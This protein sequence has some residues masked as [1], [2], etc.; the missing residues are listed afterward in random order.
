VTGI[1]VRSWAHRPQAS[2]RSQ[3]SIPRAS[4]SGPEKGK[5]KDGAR[6]KAWCAGSGKRV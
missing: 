4:G 1:R 5:V 3:G 6:N 2:R